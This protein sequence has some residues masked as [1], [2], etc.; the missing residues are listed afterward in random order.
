M[1]DIIRIFGSVSNECN[2]K[3]ETSRST[4]RNTPVKVM[5]DLK[6]LPANKAFFQLA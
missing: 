3:P 1:K 4:E 5:N 2:K 6:F